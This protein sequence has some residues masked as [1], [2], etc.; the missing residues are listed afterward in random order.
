MASNIN[1]TRNYDIDGR[2]YHNTSNESRSRINSAR[3]SDV[4]SRNY[5]AA[6]HNTGGAKIFS[7]KGGAL[8]TGILTNVI[9]WLVI[10]A[11]AF[12]G[13]NFLWP[14]IKKWKTNIDP[15]TDSTITKANQ[16]V[17]KHSSDRLSNG[18]TY[19]SAAGY[20]Y[21]ELFGDGFFPWAKKTDHDVVGRFMLSVT[22]SEW[23]QLENTY[24][25]YKKENHGLLKWGSGDEGLSFD[26]RDLFTPAE[27]I[28]YLSHLNILF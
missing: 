19:I 7:F 16:E 20:L 6:T 15:T 9:M 23:V 12:L 17:L 22:S 28:K 11:I 4:D 26:L 21:N 8:G 1:S 13:F 27:R 25:L 5:S 24:A 18:Q 10:G 3:R 14:L 2:T